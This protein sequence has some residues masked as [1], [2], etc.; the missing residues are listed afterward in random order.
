MANYSGRL[1]PE[2]QQCLYPPHGRAFRRPRG[3]Y[4]RADTNHY[5]SGRKYFMYFITLALMKF[6]ICTS[7]IHTTLYTYIP[8][9]IYKYT[10]TH[11]Y[12]LLTSA[13]GSP[14][15][16]RSKKQSVWILC[17]G[18]VAEMSVRGFSAVPDPVEGN[19]G[20]PPKRTAYSKTSSEITLCPW[21]LGARSPGASWHPS[22]RR[23]QVSCS[24]RD[25]N[26]C[27]GARQPHAAAGV[28]G[29]QALPP[30]LPSAHSSPWAHV[31]EGSLQLH[32]SD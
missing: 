23:R 5:I 17:L 21:P 13:S 14:V 30:C 3:I 28:P 11:I 26:P 31:E 16:Q 8:I 24:P 32:P 6:G 27:R 15:S 22:W 20:H 10:H 12:I 1:A 2:R 7:T 25:P 4:C 19:L 29:H 18:S 9:D